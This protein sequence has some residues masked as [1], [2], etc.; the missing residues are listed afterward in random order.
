VI[1]KA[2][3]NSELVIKLIR[4]GKEETV[5]VSVPK[6]RKLIIQRGVFVSG[7]L[8]SNPPNAP[9]GKPIINV[10]YVERASF[11]DEVSVRVDDVIHSIDGNLIASYDDVL[12]ALQGKEGKDID[13]IVRREIPRERDNY[14]F[15]VKRVEIDKAV[16]VTENGPAK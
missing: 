16:L 4:G 11:G 6:E 12:K 3:G 15:L 5:T 10:Q 8:L 1:D 14:N 13:F 2:R 9:A 7:L